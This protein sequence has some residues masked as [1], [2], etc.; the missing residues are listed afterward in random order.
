MCNL[1]NLSSERACA[2]LLRVQSESDYQLRARLKTPIAREHLGREFAPIID[3][4]Q[5]VEVFNGDIVASVM[6]VMKNHRLAQNYAQKYEVS[7][8]GMDLY[9]LEP[10]TSGTTGRKL[11]RMDHERRERPPLL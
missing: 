7:S 5:D 8:L 2:F 10:S 4:Q 9:T 3:H 6:L 1:R 11:C